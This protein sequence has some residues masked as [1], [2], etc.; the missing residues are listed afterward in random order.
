MPRNHLITDRAHFEIPVTLPAELFEQV[1]I[2]TTTRAPLWVGLWKDRWLSITLL[3]ISLILLTILFSWQR[4][5][6]RFPRAMHVFRW[7]FLVYTVA[8]LGFYAQGQLSV[9]NIYT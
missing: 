8:Y 7:G 5:F 6:T 2:E 1:E 3:T 9:V 4:Y